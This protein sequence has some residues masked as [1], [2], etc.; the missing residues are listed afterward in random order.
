[1]TPLLTLVA[2]AAQVLRTRQRA[3]VLDIDAAQLIAVVL[4]AGSLLLAAFLAACVV[5]LGR[6]IPASDLAVHVTAS[7]LDVSVQ[8][9]IRT[10]FHVT[11]CLAGVRITCAS[12]GD[13]NGGRA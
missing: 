6:Q 8:I 2:S 11:R 7:T 1:M 5:G 13:F 4:A 10:L 3:N 12:E 9:T